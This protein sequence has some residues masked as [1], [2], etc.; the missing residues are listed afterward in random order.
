M[1]N[2]DF[3]MEK[4]NHEDYHQ[5]LFILELDVSIIGLTY[6]LELSHY[7][8]LGGSLGSPLVRKRTTPKI[9]L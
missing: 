9:V 6:L 8:G 3:L 4:K 5:V 7:F 2:L 1:V